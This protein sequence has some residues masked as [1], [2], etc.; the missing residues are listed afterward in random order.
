MAFFKYKAKDGPE[1]IVE[2]KIEASSREEAIRRIEELGYFPLKIEE[3][4]EEEFQRVI[5]Q[6]GKVYPR[7]ITL[8]SRQLATLIKSGVPILRGLTILGEETTNPYFRNIIASISQ[9]L[10]EGAKFSEALNK[11]PK[12]FSSFYVAMVEA[13]EGSGKLEEVLFR[14]ADYRQAREEIISKVKLALVYPS[15]MLLVGVFTVVFMLVFVIPKLTLVFENL[16]QNLPFITQLLISLSKGF[17]QKGVV[18]LIVIFVLALILRKQAKT[19]SGR[20]FLSRVKLKIPVLGKLLLKRDLALLSRSLQLLLKSGLSILKAI[21]L[22]IPLIENDIL[23]ESFIEGYKELKQGSFLGRTLKRFKVFPAFMV[24]LI[25][26]G[27][28]SGKLDL[29]LEELASSYEKDTERILKVFT[30]ILEP[31]MILLIGIILGFVVIGMLL[32]IFQINLII[33]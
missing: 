25:S 16:G 29:A 15:I 1:R 20:R 2:G 12:I 19:K 4:S 10:K 31:A 11:Y 23:K 3:V 17:S 22:T 18:I 26:I 9:E 21:E 30:T 8:F 13:G 27:E 7:E 28:E 24:S 6:R 5:S 32:P 14:L 33:R